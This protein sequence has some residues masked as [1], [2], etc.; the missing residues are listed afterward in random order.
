MNTANRVALFVLFA[1]GTVACDKKAASDTA[2][3][4]SSA[5][6]TGASPAVP[7]GGGAPAAAD[8]VVATCTDPDTKICKEYLGTAPTL[9]ADLCKGLEGH[10]VFA[11]GKTP[12]SREKLSGTC[13]VKSD[14]ANEVHLYYLQGEA[15]ETD[16]A[17]VNKVGCEMK[18]GK[19]TAAPPSAK[20][21]AAP[22]APKAPAGKPAKKK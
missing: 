2:A 12:C 15:S 16:Q 10:G 1:V 19:W 5:A 4:A 20:P 9:A 7:A 13:V 6:L 3:A 22:A 17:D 21:A 14:T 11:N 18:E 8:A